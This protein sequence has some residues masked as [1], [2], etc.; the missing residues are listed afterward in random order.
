MHKRTALIVLAAL[1]VANVVTWS[2]RNSQAGPAASVFNQLDLLV[3][4][5]HELV[6]WYVEVPDE[7]KMVD[8]AVRAMVESLDDPFT[9]YLSPDDLQS[10]DKAV[11]GTFSGIGAE[12]DVQDRYLTIVSPLED[13]PAWKAGILA[14]DTV[15][16]IDG[17]STLDM[18]VTDA[19][20]KLTG[21]AGTQVKMLIR[22]KNGEEKLLT[23]TRAAINV[24]TV[25]GLDRDDSGHWDYTLDP[26]NNVA[27][28][29]LSQFTGKSADDFEAAAKDL[30]VRGVKGLVIDLR[31]N[32]GG[33]LDA[34]VR[35]SDIFLPEGKRIVSVNG[36][37]VKEAVYSS[38]SATILPDIPV[39]LIAN[40][41]SA[42]ASEVVSG[43]LTD[44]GRAQLVGTRTFGK[45]SVQQVLKLN[46]DLGALKITNA[47]YYLPNGRNI[48]RRKGNDTWGVDPLD[49]FYVPMN[50]EAV[51][52]MLDVRRNDAT[53]KLIRQRLAAKTVTPEWIEQDLADPQLAAALRAVLGKINTGQWPV[54]GES[55]AHHYAMLN[56]MENLERQKAAMSDRIA[57]IDQELERLRAGDTPNTPVDAVEGTIKEDVKEPVEEPVAP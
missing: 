11:R 5:R 30:K 1:L 15:L 27:Y 48:H 4:V 47:Y 41:S 38:T 18:S 50:T 34:A 24:P 49:G 26:T 44:N 43:A 16:E 35:I 33:L 39:V 12:V 29:R 45:G 7:D 8:S 6:R 36:R 10:F 20:S 21:E 31:F 52:K 19:V 37:S 40:E 53:R 51:Q 54:V 22:H 13:S 23:I 55:D 3:D 25:R 2:V 57:Q 56:Q 14:G 32:P 28:I 9:T 42:S 17:V 46:D